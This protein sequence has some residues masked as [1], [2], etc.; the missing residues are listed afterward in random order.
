MAKLMKPL[1]I[2]GMYNREGK[3]I[4]VNYL[5]TIGEYPL[6]IEDGKPNKD[7]TSNERDKYYLYIEF[8][9]WIVMTGYTEYQLEQKAGYEYL[10]KE[11][12]GDFEGRQKYFEDNFYKGRK[13]EEYSPLLKE[14]VAK[15]EAFIKEWGKNETVQAELL[16]S[17]IDRSIKRYIEA[18]DNGG[19]FAD[20]I[21]PLS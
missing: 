1:F 15:E 4:R 7:Y 11:W 16:K 6:W 13:Y 10:N 2:G 20:F 21:G 19:K 5:K 17:D 9:N 8:E 3:R 18:R 12:Y 14:Q